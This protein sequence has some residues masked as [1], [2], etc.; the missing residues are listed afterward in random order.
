MA[1]LFNR[2]VSCD[3]CL[4]F[5]CQT[6]VDCYERDGPAPDCEDSFKFKGDGYCDE[7]CNHPE[8]GFDDGD[9]CLD[10]V[11]GTYCSSCF[12]YEDCTYHE[13]KQNLNYEVTDS[14]VGK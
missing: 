8:H 7:V 11:D 14:I 4:C 5:E 6:E 12:C 13:L 3:I 9:C 2:F 10:I 1:K